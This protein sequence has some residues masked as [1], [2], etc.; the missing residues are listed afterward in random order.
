MKHMFTV[1]HEEP[2]PYRGAYLRPHTEEATAWARRMNPGDIIEVDVV[3][4]RSQQHHRLFFAMLKI[5]NDNRDGGS[6]DELLDIIKIGAGHTYVV[7]LP[8]GFLYRVPK[9]VSFAKMDQDQ[10]SAFFNSAVDYIVSDI[11]PG[12]DKA[13]LTAE[14]YAAA[15]IPMALLDDTR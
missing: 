4:P 6:V 12:I 13:A 2:Y 15:G 8:G 1:C 5:V 14:I 9:S 3:R 10:F 11:L 7:E